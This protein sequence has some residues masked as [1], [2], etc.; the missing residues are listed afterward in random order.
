MQAVRLKLALLINNQYTNEV[1]RFFI[2][3]ILALKSF[4]PQED[5]AG[6]D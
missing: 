4:T 2:T 3:Y 1:I 5:T 6:I